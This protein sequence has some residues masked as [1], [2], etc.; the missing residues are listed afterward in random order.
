[1]LKIPVTEEPRNKA[2]ANSV[3]PS[4]RHVFESPNFFLFFFIVKYSAN[5]AFGFKAN[6]AIRHTF[7]GPLAIFY[8]AIAHFST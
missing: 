1:M 7:L 5:K 8:S 4:I 2:S 6:R 3:N